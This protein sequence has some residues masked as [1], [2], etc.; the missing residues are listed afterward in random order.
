MLVPKKYVLSLSVLIFLVLF[1][2]V[3]IILKPSFLYN[4]DGSIKQF[5]L[6]YSRKTVIPFWLMTIGLAVI[7]YLL[8]FYF[9]IV[10]VVF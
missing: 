1:Y 6:G 4:T 5:G 9:S 2:V 7:S 3:S 10:K 8:V